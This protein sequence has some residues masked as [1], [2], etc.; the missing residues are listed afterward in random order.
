MFIHDASRATFSFFSRFWIGSS[1][2]FG[3]DDVGTSGS[4]C[5]KKPFWDCKIKWNMKLHALTSHNMFSLITIYQQS[6]K[7]YMS[8]LTLIHCT[9]FLSLKRFHC[10]SS[11]FH[12]FLL[13]TLKIFSKQKSSNKKKWAEILILCVLR[14][15]I[16]EKSSNKPKPIQDK[17]CSNTLCQDSKTNFLINCILRGEKSSEFYFCRLHIGRAELT[18]QQ[19][20]NLLKRGSSRS[21]THHSLISTILLF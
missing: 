9:S 16:L 14:P 10:I 15:N 11:N 6:Y 5:C 3:N 17:T 1:T 21:D 18:R 8:I 13:K 12:L 2:D 20:W 4:F 7:Q 19:I